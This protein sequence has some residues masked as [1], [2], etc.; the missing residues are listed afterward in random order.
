MIAALRRLLA[1]RAQPLPPRW[2]TALLAASGVAVAAM[3][4]WAWRSSGLAWSD[5][6]W[7]AVAVLFGVL[8]PLSLALKAVEFVLAAR[9]AGQHPGRREALDVAVVS[10]A[11]NLLPIP[12]SLMVTVQSIAGSGATYG[13]AIAASAVPGLTWLAITALIGGGATAAL[14]APLVGA[15]LVCAAPVAGAAAWRLFARSVPRGRRAP[16]AAAIIAA[17]TGWLAVSAGRLGLA[18]VALGQSVTVGQALALSVAGALTVAI[19]F[20]PGGLGVREALLAGLS[21]LIGLDVET[22]VLLGTLDRVVWL[23]FLGLAGLISAVGRNR[24]APSTGS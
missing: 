3:A 16:L 13:G 14:G 21:P 17:E 11:A 15:L 23:A 8:A 20:F 18:V 6:R 19:G 2:R 5:L 9:I 12:G 7:W 10:S 22:G 4:L 1:R 24:P